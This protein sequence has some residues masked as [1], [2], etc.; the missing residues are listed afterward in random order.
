MGTLDNSSQ[1]GEG[2]GVGGGRCLAELG[3]AIFAIGVLVWVQ[4]Q[5]QLLVRGFHLLHGLGDD[6]TTTRQSMQTEAK[7]QAAEMRAQQREHAVPHGINK[8]HWG[9]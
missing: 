1:K 8:Q 3:R 6:E 5:R 9:G 7:M 2:E 4:L